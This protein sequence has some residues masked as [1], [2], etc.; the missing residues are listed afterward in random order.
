MTTVKK[1]VWGDGLAFAAVVLLGGVLKADRDGGDQRF[2]GNDAAIRDHAAKLVRDGREIFRF[3]TFGSEAFWGG[4]LRLHQTIAGAANRG[5]G[6][7][8]SPRAALSLGLKVD[9]DAL[10]PDLVNAIKRGAVNLDDPATTLSLLKLD[11]VVG[12]KGIFGTDGKL[13]SVGIRCALCHSTVNQS[14][15][16]NAIPAGNIGKRLDGWPARD[17]NVGAV[18]AFAPTV[19]PFADLL[20]VDESTV[21]RVLMSWGPGKFDAELILDGKAFRPDG[22]SAATL[23]PP[24]FGLAG[25]SQ[26]TYTGWGGIAHWNAFV[27][28]LEMA[29]SG[30]FW[31]PRLNDASRFPIAAKAGFGDR[32]PE[33]DLVTSKLAALH[34]YQI[35][36]PAPSQERNPFDWRVRN[37]E[38]LFNGKAQCATCHVP[39][40][41]TEPGWN[42]HTPEEI[43]I[44][45]FQASRSPDRRYRTTP[46]AG[47]VAKRKGGFYHDGRFPTLR[48]VVNHYD[49]HFDLRL[50]EEEK[51]DLVAFLASL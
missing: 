24:A 30:R 10:P 18:I 4:A 31:D 25:S 34:A 6:P 22:N 16:T 50:T 1:P 47:M 48:N 13:A 9:A 3:D 15:S 8:L 42:M 38:S 39:P 33:K 29:G 45:D 46:L 7:G 32:R 2:E 41:Y 20:G 19:K 21:R 49:R 11:A 28:N 44:D 23:L 17:L 36:I 12:V 35:A 5:V 26:H 43:G 51:R 14:F 40:L 37:G 27:A